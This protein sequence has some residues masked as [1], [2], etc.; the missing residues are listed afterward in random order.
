MTTTNQII[1][2]AQVKDPTAKDIIASYQKSMVSQRNTAYKEGKRMDKDTLQSYL[3]VVK[4]ELWDCNFLGVAHT[5]GLFH[6]HLQSLPKV[7]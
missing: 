7:V 1:Q 3:D 2:I 5:M 6:N 4:E